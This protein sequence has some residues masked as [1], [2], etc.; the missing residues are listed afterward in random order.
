VIDKMTSIYQMKET[1]H[2]K[3]LKG[4]LAYETTACIVTTT[5]LY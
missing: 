2:R 4:L 5:V 3:L 1:R